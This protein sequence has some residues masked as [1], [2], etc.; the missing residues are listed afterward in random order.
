VARKFPPNKVHPKK[1]SPSHWTVPPPASASA[2]R[3]RSPALLHVHKCSVLPRSR[4]Q[5]LSPA[6][7]WPPQACARLLSAQD[8]PP[9]QVIARRNQNS[10]PVPLTP[11]H[12]NQPR[13]FAEHSA[14]HSADQRSR[15]CSV[16]Q[17]SRKA[18]L[19]KESAMESSA[20]QAFL[21]D[22]P[23]RSRP[24]P[25]QRRLRQ[26]A[27]LVSLRASLPNPHHSAPNPALA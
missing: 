20:P 14:E 10:Q 3:D 1:S 27:G 24:E 5:Q 9:P 25:L 6:Q 22:S 21:P 8:S 26:P 2:A 13:C 16:S 11:A 19:A 23:P 4:N 18:W 7:A 12:S 15:R 17:G